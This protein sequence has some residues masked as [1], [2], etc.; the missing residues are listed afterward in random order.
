MNESKVHTYIDDNNF[1]W[2]TVNR[3][4]KRNAIDYDVMNALKAALVEVRENT[5]IRGFIITGS[6][7]QSFCSG[8][9]L[10]VFHALHTKE[11]AYSMLSKM[12]DVLHNLMT[13]PVPTY[14]LINGTAIGGGCEIASA[15]DQ[16]WAAPDAKLGFVQGK[17]GI[18]TGWGG[19][20]MLMEKLPHA[21]AIQMLTSAKIFSSEE[22]M[23]FGFIQKIVPSFDSQ[24]IQEEL[25]LSSAVLRSYKKSF[26]SKWDQTSLKERM[27]A[28]I[29]QCSILWEQEEHH[30]AV[31]TFLES[32]KL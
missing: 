26:I 6:G 23:E 22:A 1:Y 27:L 15:C 8:G 3:P 5:A 25:T 29:E 21:Q 24:S 4:E 17:L 20:S 14:A 12:G 28:E 7:Q 2:F 13:L 18:T 11:D 19:A 31:N 10:S 9:D 16:R 30:E 32:K